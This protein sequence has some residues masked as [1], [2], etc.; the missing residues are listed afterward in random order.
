MSENCLNCVNQ[1]TSNFCAQC[2]QKASVHRYS[3]KHFIEHD[4]IH[5]IWHIDNGI[6]FTIKELF[7]RPGHSIREYI[8]GKRVGYFNFVTL[9]VI[10]IGISHFLGEF[11]QV[12]ISDLLPES[13]KAAMN[14]F[15]EFTQKNP[16][17]TLLL[18]IPLYSIFSFLW[19]RN[20]KLNLT[21]HFVLNSYKTVAESL[22]ALLFTITTIFYTNIKGLTT[23]YSIIGLFTLVYAFYFYKQFF[24]DYGYSKKSLII[25]SVGVVFSYILLSIFVGVIMG[26]MKYGK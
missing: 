1:I 22:I 6:F 18:T 24:S 9:L 3:I 13:S 17:S 7:T 11:S 4:L 14:E 25:R 12:K 2:G 10:T 8:N 23:I 21:E 16:K 19:F 26:I 5:G 20:S 15:Q